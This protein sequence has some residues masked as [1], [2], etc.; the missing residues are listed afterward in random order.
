MSH[1]RIQNGFVQFYTVLTDGQFGDEHGVGRDQ[2]GVG[3]HLYNR[4]DPSYTQHNQKRHYPDNACEHIGAIR[5]QRGLVR[6]K[7][8]EHGLAFF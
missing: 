4:Q 7:K 2:L 1:H 8:I 5:E 3:Q 6:Q